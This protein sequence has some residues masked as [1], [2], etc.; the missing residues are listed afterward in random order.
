MAI[1]T[2]YDEEI[3]IPSEFDAGVYRLASEDCVCAGIGDEFALNYSASS[4]QVSFNVGSQAVL[5]GGFF[6]VTSQTSI[7][8][9]ANSTI[10]LCA[11]IDKSQQVKG[12]FQALSASQIQKQNINGSGTVRD[13]VLYEVKTNA[14]GVTSIT[15]KRV[16]RD[17][18]EGAFNDRVSELEEDIADLSDSLGTQV[19]YQVV[20]NTLRITTK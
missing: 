10:Q 6:R 15:D 14:N 8:L 4:L 9:P 3:T 7:T 16:I 2:I 12:S 17:T 18:V 13:L 1:Q 5:C 19:T 20:G 11:R